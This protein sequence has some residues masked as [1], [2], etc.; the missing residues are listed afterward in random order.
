MKKRFMLVTAI[1]LAVVLAGCST[2]ERVLIS[3]VLDDYEHFLNAGDINPLM[4]LFADVSVYTTFDNVTLF[5]KADIR[6]YLASI[7]DDG[8]EVRLKVQGTAANAEIYFREEVNLA[9]DTSSLEGWMQMRDGKIQIIGQ[10]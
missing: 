2:G 10:E 6:E 5:G 4:G 8:V 1:V 7:I 9:G 3:D